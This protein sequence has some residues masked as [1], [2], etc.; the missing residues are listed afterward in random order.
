VLVF[1]STSLNDKRHVEFAKRFGELDDI[2]PYLAAGRKNRLA[3]D[4]LF[5]V[6]NLDLD[7]TVV[8]SKAPRAQANK[9]RKKPPKDLVLIPLLLLKALLIL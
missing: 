2:K 8:E 6:S 5:D 3:Y 1:R 9:V 4:E 7:G